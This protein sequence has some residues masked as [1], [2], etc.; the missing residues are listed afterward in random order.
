MRPTQRLGSHPSADYLIERGHAGGTENQEE[1]ARPSTSRSGSLKSGARGRGV[2]ETGD[3]DAGVWSV[4]LA[5]RLIMFIS[6]CG[7]ARSYH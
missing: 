4:G 5:A 2:D 1:Q 6:R 3:I 7:R